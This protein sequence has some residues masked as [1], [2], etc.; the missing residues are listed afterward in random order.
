MSEWVSK[1]WERSSAPTCAL[2]SVRSLRGH[3]H[4]LS[5]LRVLRKL[6]SLLTYLLTYLLTHADDL[7]VGVHAQLA[8][9]CVQLC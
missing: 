3:M 8:L 1:Q 6:S 4:M 9:D 5:V 2:K 7:Q